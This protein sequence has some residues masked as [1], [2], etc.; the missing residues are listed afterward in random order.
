MPCP[1]P[2]TRWPTNI[3]AQPN[4][5][6][7]GVWFRDYGYGIRN[8][9]VAM[10]IGYD[11]FHDLLTPA[12]QTQLQT[13]L[14]NWL[15]GFETGRT[16]SQGVPQGNFE[17]DHPQGNYFA[18]YYAAKCMAA[19]AVEGDSPL[20]TAWWNDW[21]NHQHLQRVAPYYEPIWR[22]ADGTKATR[23]T[24]FWRRAISHC[25]RWP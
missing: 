16:D 11:W 8:F 14:N 19:L 23:N 1:T 7:C 9:G 18:G 6:K 5:A 3:L 15:F 12:H 20:G 13:A 17:Y 21:Y 24:A 4:D 2:P 10:G 22:A 25:R